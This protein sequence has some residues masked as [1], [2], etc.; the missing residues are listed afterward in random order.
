MTEAEWL[1]C[2]EPWN[3]LKSIQ[4]PRGW[5]GGWSKHLFGWL[6][7]KH[8]VVSDRKLQMLVN[9]YCRRHDGLLT[10]ERDKRTLK[11]SES[12]TEGLVGIEELGE[13]IRSCSTFGGIG[14]HPSLA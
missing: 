6:G 13:G 1:A 4:K 3:M 12:Y 5:A 8:V 7:K 11:I 9:A 2:S 14:C 10:D